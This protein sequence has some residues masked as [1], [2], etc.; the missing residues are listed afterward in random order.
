MKKVL[1]S[2]L[3]IFSIFIL[4]G[5][6]KK[7]EKEIN[8]DLDKIKES[9]SKLETGEFNRVGVYNNLFNSEYFTKELVEIYDYDKDFKDVFGFTTNYMEE[10]SIGYN[11]ETKE[12]FMVIK[13]SNNKIK[14]EVSAFLKSNNIEDKV[15]ASEYEGYLI[16][17]LAKDNN[18]VLDIIK[19][20]S[21]PVFG[22]MSEVTKDNMKD[23]LGLEANKTEEFLMMMPMM[24]VN[25]NTYIIVKPSAGEKEN[26]KAT[27]DKYMEKLEEQWKIYLPDQYQLVKN[28][29]Y[30][31]YGEYLIYIVSSDNDKV[32]N[33]IKKH[34]K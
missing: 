12:F 28:R 20:T 9:L 21:N 22:M 3:C 10:Y 6:G 19:K 7:V 17:I 32:L 23:I 29:K 24:V 27:I 5:C 8:L 34:N 26:V 18:K 2:L 31:E 25:S 14:D 15:L 30:E 1:I 33:E 4:V 16:Y 11:K 13:A